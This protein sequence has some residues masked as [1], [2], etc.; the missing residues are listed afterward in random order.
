M[1]TLRDD[2]DYEL[3]Q[4][5]MWI[6]NV[7]HGISAFHDTPYNYTVFRNVMDFGCKGDGIADDTVCINTAISSGARCGHNCGSSTIHPGL[8]YFPSGKYK[9]SSPIIMYYYSQLVGNALDP[10]TIVAASEFQGI[11]MI[12]ANPYDEAGN[13]WY[14]NQNNFFRQIRNFIVDTTA[15]PSSATTTGVHWQV[16]QATSLVKLHF[17]MTFGSNH[18]GIWIE[19]GSGGFMSD[20]KFE[21]GKF[22]MHVGNQ[23]FLSLRMTFD[24]CDT[25]I[26]ISWARHNNFATFI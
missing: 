2:D 3:S 10:P 22:G 25:A 7:E 1:H 13:N 15:T 5:E 12:D 9:I 4:K 18:R 17:K 20:L 19:N 24:H 14:T 16:A 8:I 26:Y 11:S 6:A 21:G 23:Q